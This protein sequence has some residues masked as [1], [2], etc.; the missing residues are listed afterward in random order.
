MFLCFQ[1]YKTKV[2][3]LKFFACYITFL[4][5][6]NVFHKLKFICVLKIKVWLMPKA[7]IIM[8]FVHAACWVTHRFCTPFP[9][10]LC[11]VTTSLSLV[12]YT[13]FVHVAHSVTHRLRPLFPAVLCLVTTPLSPVYRTV[14]FHTA[15][16]MIHHLYLP[17]TAC[18]CVHEASS[19]GVLTD[20][21][22][23]QL[24]SMLSEF[25]FHAK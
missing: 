20:C 23:C 11:S 10:V 1:F 9:T 13:V 8:L 5:L 3:K 22:C 12:S 6:Q 2:T 19:M 21:H 17:P 14:F 16:W 7:V 25:W 24:T 18:F 15:R 4:K